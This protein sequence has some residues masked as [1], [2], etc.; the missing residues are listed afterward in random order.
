MNLS[1]PQWYHNRELSWL[2][3]NRRVLQ[4]ALD[5]TNPLLERLKFLGITFS[6]L[7]EFFMIR[8]A[9]IKE[10]IEVGFRGT[11]PA[12]MTPTQ[13]MT[14]ISKAVKDMTH[15]SYICLQR[16]IIPSLRKEGCWFSSI[17]E[18]SEKAHHFLE[19]YF[20][21]TI[22]SVLTPMAIDPSRPFPNLQNRSL[23]L[24]VTLKTPKK[25]GRYAIVPIPSVLPR[26]VQVPSDTQAHFVFLEQIIIEFIDSLFTGH[27]IVRVDPFRITRNADLEIEEEEADDLLEEIQRSLKRRHWGFPVRLEVNRGISGRAL[28]FLAKVCELEEEDIYQVSGPLDLSTFLKSPIKKGFETLYDLPQ[29]PQ[30]IALFRDSDSVFDVI[31]EQDVI[32]HHPFETFQHVID[33]LNH[34]SVD[35]HV[36]AI[37]QTLY[38]V[39]GDS[40][41]I[42][43][44]IRAA[45]NGKQVTVLVEL[46]ARFDEEN[47]ILWAKRLEDAGCHVVYGLMGLKTHCKVLLVVRREEDGI[48]R[49][50][51]MSTGNYNDKT[52]ALYTDIGFFTTREPFG[53]DASSLFNVLTGFARPPVWKTIAF[54]PINLRQSFMESIQQEIHYAQTGMEARIILKMNSLVDPQMIQA[55]YQASMAGV[56]IDLIVRGI[57]CLKP[58]VPG[59]SDRIRVRSIVGRYLEHT[60][61][62][63]FL[64]GGDTRVFL[65][66][67][68]WMPRNLDRRVEILFPLED[69]CLKERIYDIL[70]LY[71]RDTEKAREMHADGHY[72]RVD[73]RGKT[74]LNAQEELF[75]QAAKAA[76][77]KKP[78]EKGLFKVHSRPEESEDEWS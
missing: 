57:C 37:K 34:A 16:S 15:V 55:L 32:L 70:D 19:G 75:K 58:G 27:E 21:D 67:A 76:I 12:G 77:P 61:I 20:E 11:D 17:T 47:N 46:K 64:N 51:H 74:R 3:F 59:L 8:V 60:R 39:S 65:S 44:L 73:K 63:Y 28:S 26:L 18:V 52:A 35:P 14:E 23:N 10:Q 25:K 41:V 53:Y 48:R 9:G 6:N 13:Q 66:S 2:Q 38:R 50:V 29:L 31:R 36:L 40:P 71:L 56:E 1:D 69:E 42:K 68:D 7:D 22:Y 43:A 45:E 49:Y 54:A 33:F 62:F 72:T 30:T 78:Q 24:L 5:R 4:E